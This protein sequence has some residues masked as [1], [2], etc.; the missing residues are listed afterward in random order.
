MYG[1]FWDENKGTGWGTCDAVA[2]LEVELS[3]DDIEELI[4]RTVDVE[5]RSTRQ[6]AR[7]PPHPKRAARLFISCENVGDVFLATN[8][9]HEMRST[10]GEHDEPLFLMRHH[11]WPQGEDDP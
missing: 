10:I 7:V 3:F 1:I 11:C 4:F 5:G 9:T 2:K 8:G 6:G